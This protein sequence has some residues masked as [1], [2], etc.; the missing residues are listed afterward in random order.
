MTAA[1]NT[2][3]EMPATNYKNLLQK[4]PT[5]QP[6]CNCPDHIGCKTFNI[7]VMLVV[8]FLAVPDLTYLTH[9]TMSQKKSLQPCI[10]TR[11]TDHQF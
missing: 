5:R 8:L 11:S 1:I 10:V 9:V 4:S 7:L 2:V 3:K 6:I